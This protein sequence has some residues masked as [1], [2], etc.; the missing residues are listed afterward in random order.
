MPPT[1]AWREDGDLV[2]RFNVMQGPGQMPLTPGTWR[3]AASPSDRAVAR[4]HPVVV[5][6]PEDLAA[7]QSTAIFETPRGSYRVALRHAAG[8][9]LLLNVSLDP[10]VGAFPASGMQAPGVI[11]R[12]RR[13]GRRLRRAIFWSAV[14]LLRRVSAGPRPAVL[15]TSSTR[16]ALGGNLAA[17]HDRMVER[18]LRRD[19]DI[20]L[21]FKPDIHAPTSLRERLRMPWLLARADVIVIDDFHPVV[22]GID[23]PRVRIV[24]LWHASGVVKTILY[25]R[26]GKPGG[27]DPGRA[28]TRTTPMRS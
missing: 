26:T 2:A 3:L 14:S 15:F 7:R 5:A 22:G 6:D 16:P 20:L 21:S 18:G 10:P 13:F 12:A 25:S 4:D 23:D 19:T 27:P 11:S 1:R 9:G 28:T 8:L 17:V 24:Q